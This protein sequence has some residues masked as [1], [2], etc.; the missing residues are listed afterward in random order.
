MSS[1]M[2]T[3]QTVGF[4]VG[5]VIGFFYGDY[6]F[7]TAALFASIGGAIGGAIDPPKGPKLTG[8]RLGDLSQQVSSY[9]AP[10]P[11]I[12]GCAALFGNI[13]WIENN[14]L[15]ETGKT[16]GGGKG[17][18]GGA[19]TT[20]YTYSATF[21]L[22]LC[23]GPIDGV[24]RI[25]IGGTLVYDAGSNDPST[26]IA[27]SNASASWKL[28]NG[29]EDQMPS[30]RMQAALGVANTPA[31]RGLAYLV[32]ED[33]ELG[34]YG[35]TLMGA[36]I[37]V[38][39]L[40]SS[41]AS[42]ITQV[43]TL[44]LSGSPAS[45]GSS[46][47]HCSSAGIVDVFRQS[48]TGYY[49]RTRYAASENTEIDQDMFVQASANTPFFGWSDRAEIAYPY[50]AGGWY[51]NCQDKNGFIWFSAEFPLYLVGGQLTAF[52]RRRKEVV[53]HL[54]NGGAGEVYDLSLGFPVLLIST[55]PGSTKGA[56]SA[57]F[58]GENVN[59]GLTTKK[60]FICYDKNWIELWSHDMTSSTMDTINYALAGTL[61]CIR[62]IST[63]G[64]ACLNVGYKFWKVSEAGWDYLGE[65]PTAWG[66]TWLP[67][68][69][70][71]GGAHCIYPLWLWH[72]PSTNKMA[73][74]NLSGIYNGQ[75]PLSDIVRA[76][77]LKSNILQ[78]ADVDVL[79]LTDSV[80]GYRISSV[81]ALRAAIEPLQ[82]AWPFDVIQSGYK[83]KFV[84][85]GLASSGASIDEIEL[86]ARKAG[87]K[88][89]IR[90]S[91]SREMDTQLP[92]RVSITHLDYDR[93]YDIGEQYAERLNTLS[94]N[95]RTVDM[96][97]VLTSTEAA[98]LAEVLLYMCWL[99]RYAVSFKLPPTYNELEPA[100]TVTVT[101][102]GVSHEL[103]I[104]E[105]GYG[106]DGIIEVSAKLNEN[107]LYQSQATGAQATAVSG[108][109][110]VA[111]P[112]A[113]ALL[114]IPL[115]L[116]DYDT[117]G[118]PVAMA[119][120]LSGWHGATLFRSDDAGQ[121]WIGSN[122]TATAS[123]IGRCLNIIGSPADTRMVDFAS[124]L[125]VKLLSG[126]LSSVTELQMLNG[127]NYFA[128]GNDTRW[129]II[130]ARTC[131]LQGDGSY[132]LTDILRGRFGTEWATGTHVIGD[133]LVYLGLNALQFCTMSLNQIGLQKSWRPVSI[134][135]TLESAAI[136]D[137]T[138]RGVNLE[139]LSP[140][141]LNGSRHPSTNDWTLS[142]LRRTRVG[143][144][145]R[146]KVDATLGE[147]SEAYELEI[148]SS[149]A[150]TTLKR[151]IAGLT[152]PDA[153]Y[154]SAQQVTD[155][156]SN[157][158]TLYVRIYQLSATVGRGYPLQTAI[159][160]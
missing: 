55:A 85:R 89:G 6:S 90:F 141:W 139:C 20:T 140:V 75:V 144:E 15:K 66:A 117:A 24:R 44:T 25:W 46:A 113:M 4:V 91:R 27:S 94:I 43:S 98:R 158:A 51:L 131:T 68:F 84:R 61:G 60:W 3:G 100:D 116:D 142:W 65:V 120:Y 146:D 76:E 115:L 33:L 112:T 101:A 125:S 128:Y 118:F 83:V 129:E 7:Q 67:L 47:M 105:M 8:P 13:F 79:S 12:Y 59:Y 81:G 150:Y 9:G 130:A 49:V 143:G 53:A 157:Q 137:Y 63:D 154:T 45:F 57:I 18:G 62:E 31:Y 148:Y 149:A 16:E 111:G 58:L 92:N 156:G 127:A 93:E 34:K 138:Y 23:E 103:R 114:D 37:K 152:T 22:G 41:T 40:K 69:Y 10:I 136:A 97:I 126:S 52:Y 1:N 102:A 21:A 106:P 42:G 28:Y 2:S 14:A 64:V 160:R 147:T 104:I 11:R 132:I 87:D 32:F 50:Y 72:S 77:C 30:P 122:A 80:R 71:N 56:L 19:E 86:D 124:A 107:A 78:T 108:S 109:I 17:G 36:Q 134:G 29:A 73:V 159:T 153:S 70:P 26:V 110:G 95:L 99:E 38:E 39:V 135:E 54:P 5:A 82:G 119:G 35:N 155:F 96:P 74:I 133:A 48:G 121:T 123:I 145:W 88:P 151:T